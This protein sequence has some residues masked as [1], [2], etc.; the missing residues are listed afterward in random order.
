M[1]RLKGL[2]DG[3]NPMWSQKNKSLLIDDPMRHPSLWE[4]VVS[5]VVF[6]QIHGTHGGLVGALGCLTPFDGLGIYKPDFEIVVQGHTCNSYFQAGTWVGL[7]DFEVNNRCDDK[8]FIALNDNSKIWTVPEFDPKFPVSFLHLFCGGFNGWERATK[9]MEL[10]RVITI[11]KEIAIDRDEQAMQVWQLRSKGKLIFGNIRHDFVCNEKHIGCVAMAS[12]N[13]WMNLVRILMNEIFTCSPPCVSWSRGGKS[14]GLECDSGLAFSE[15]V[16][17]IRVMRPI[18]VLFECSDQISNH[19]HYQIIRASM[20][21]AGYRQVWSQ[22]VPFDAIAKMYR[23]RWLA[24]WARA[25]I[26]D[27][28]ALGSFRIA[29]VHSGGWNSPEYDFSVPK[30]IQHQM[31]LSRE[32]KMIY[33]DPQFLPQSKKGQNAETLNVSEVLKIRCLKQCDTMPT[34]CASYSQQHL[35]DASHLRCKG[36]YAVLKYVHDDFQFFSPL[37]FTALLGATIA[38]PVFIPTKLAVAFL[39]A[40]NAIS[41]PHAILTL[42]VA[43]VALKFAN[44]TITQTVLK[45]WHDRMTVANTII[46]RCKDFCIMCPLHLVSTI[47]PTHNMSVLDPKIFPVVIIDEKSFGI[48]VSSNSIL[49]DVFQQLGFEKD[50][51]KNVICT[52]Q[53]GV[54]QWN[55]TLVAIN[56]V[57][58]SFTKFGTKFLTLVC[59]FDSCIDGCDS[60]DL[61]IRA[62][63]E[64]IESTLASRPSPMLPCIEEDESHPA[65]RICRSP[66]S[67]QEIRASLFCH[68]GIPLATDELAWIIETFAP[69]QLVNL[70]QI[71]SNHWDHLESE[72]GRVIACSIPKSLIK[73]M[74]LIDNHWFAI[75]IRNSDTIE[76]FCVNVPKDKRPRLANY[77][78]TWQDVQ[79]FKGSFAFSESSYSHGLCGWELILHWFGIVFPQ[80]DTHACAI[81]EFIRN[82]GSIAGPPP[83]D[84]RLLIM[85][86]KVCSARFHFLST[87][88]PDHPIDGIKIGFAASDQEMDDAQTKPSE[89]PDPWMQPTQDPWNQARK[90]CKWE[91]LRLPEDHHF[92]D[93]KGIR[94]SQIHR[95]QISAKTAG[96]AFATKSNVVEIFALSPPKETALLIP[97]NDKVAFPQLHQISI[98]GPYEIV[99]RDKSLNSI[100]KRQVLVVQAADEI[101]FE[102]PKAAYT[103]V[104][105]EFKELVIEIDERLVSKDLAATIAAK[106][107]DTFKAKLIE[108]IPSIASKSVG[109]F[110]FRLLKAQSNND[111]HRVF[112]AICKIHA[113]QRVM[114]LGLVQ[115]T[116]SSG[117][118]WPRARLWKISRLFPGFGKLRRLRKT[119]PFVS[120]LRSLDSQVW[121]IPAGDWRCV[122][123]ASKLPRSERYS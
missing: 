95:Q 36:I 115:V 19:P 5:D 107:L 25:D 48:R 65:K 43:F 97:N 93:K 108:Q 9:W 24:A 79:G 17:K 77:F 86:K 66:L 82:N 120:L 109:V 55:T 78:S 116:S 7:C 99:V 60:L 34:L 67:K 111:H 6:A 53:D 56:G 29:D 31:K 57:E 114:C 101:V 63:I 106:P 92:K 104:T 119:T 22:V 42:S 1:E 103:A 18:L 88:Q 38:E 110:G 14:Q 98:S 81:T 91:D 76:F 21:A 64:T 122:P 2:I 90:A 105:T 39:H 45:A 96:V 71:V 40:G 12:Q 117:T 62:Q 94:I 87:L 10:N 26:S 69:R 123:G 11:Q 3:L 37:L 49:L 58:L 16:A 8:I 102:L 44:I 51:L 13:H 74:C 27:V 85:W 118:M 84:R 35:I 54:V 89:Q 72:I 83:D 75:E 4:D 80:Y 41:V 112:Q 30:Q 28:Q 52:S 20:H 68:Q 59:R 121:F 47:L 46:F 50:A 70:V 23:T 113:D 73:C 100:Y 33:G 61:A 15:S 32:M